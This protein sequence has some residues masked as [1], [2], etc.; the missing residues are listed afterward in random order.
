MTATGRYSLIK[1]CAFYKRGM[2]GIA[3]A[4]EL[5]PGAIY[6]TAGRVG[7]PIPAA[8]RLVPLCANHDIGVQRSDLTPVS[9]KGT[10]YQKCR[11]PSNIDTDDIVKP[12]TDIRSTAYYI[13]NKNIGHFFPHSYYPFTLKH[14]LST[15]PI[16]L[17]ITCI[18]WRQEIGRERE[19]ETQ[20]KRQDLGT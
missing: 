13:V 5:G 7:G 1:I 4:L 20:T 19:G 18:S 15:L 8:D 6:C 2:L 10:G 17:I 14:P 16:S 9:G 3:A 11:L 12:N